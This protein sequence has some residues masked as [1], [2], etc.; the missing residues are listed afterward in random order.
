[1]RVLLTLLLA[2]GVVGCAVQRDCTTGTSAVCEVHYCRMERTV[3]PIHYGLMPFAPRSQARY[4]ASTNS[5][6]HARDS[7]NPSCEV[8]REREAVIYACPQCV[9][10]RQ[11]W[12]T[13]YDSRR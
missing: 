1:M 6:P 3:V 7:I 9:A 13:D 10:A 2:A 4:A 8:S 12:E 11:Q 5:F